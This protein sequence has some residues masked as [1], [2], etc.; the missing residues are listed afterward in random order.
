MRALATVALLSSLSACASHRSRDEAHA[1]A[2]PAVVDPPPPAEA[3]ASKEKNDD[4]T[5]LGP[6]CPAV[7][8]AKIEPPACDDAI[9]SVPVPAVV[10]PAGSLVH[11]HE[12]VLALA[13]GASSE[14]VRIAV[15]G[16]SN[17][18]ADMMTGHMRRVLQARFGD[19]GHGFVVLGKPKGWY[20]HQDVRRGGTWKAF[21]N[22]QVSNDLVR[23]RHYG[24]ANIASETTSPGAEA[25]VATAKQGPIGTRV[26]RFEVFYFRRPEGGTFDVLADGKVVK[27]ISTRADAFEAG[28]E[29]I[30]LDDGPHELR[31]VARGHG[32]VRFAGVALERDVPGVVVDALGTGAMN[33]GQ[34]SWVQS[35]TRRPMLARR[36]YDLVVFHLGT[37]QSMLSQHKE[38]ARKVVE[39]VRAALPRASILFLTPPDM[40]EP[41]FGTASAPRI[42]TVSKQIREV[43]AE[44]GSAF[45]DYRAAMGGDGSMR[46]FAM[47]KLAWTDWVH[48]HRAG[49]DLMGDRLMRALF[50]DLA[51]HRAEHPDAGCA[52][53]E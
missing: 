14:R 9:A 29:A 5:G 3:P 1:A 45:W 42:V 23:D 31:C 18:Q 24:F 8:E 30:V 35:S 50:M 17:A 34:M 37:A 11:F 49:H 4:G 39:D 52:R 33:I 25:W 21:R 10:D 19:G 47:K 41:R 7:D 48:L 12:R 28:V 40:L 44:T 16:D 46:T 36:D 27:T 38:W 53:V 26:A 20:G 13:R 43:A 32:P 51:R 15:Y 6:A 2:P 22:I